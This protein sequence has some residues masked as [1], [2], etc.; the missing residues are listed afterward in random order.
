MVYRLKQLID[1]HINASDGAIGKVRD[2]YFDDHSWTIRHLVLQTGSFL[3]DRQVL[4]SPVSVASID[5]DS[6][7]VWVKL[8]VQQVKGSPPIDTDKPVSRQ[9]EAD[10]FD[11]YGYPYYWT[12]PALW[13]KATYPTGPAGSGLAARNTAGLRSEAPFDSRL[14]SAKEVTGYRLLTSTEPIGH[15][16]DFLLDSVTWAIRY[17]VV[18]T[19][20]WLPGKHVVIPPGW[21]KE[22]DWEE[23]A[24]HVAVSPVSVKEAPEFDSSS[25]FSRAYETRLY[26]HYQRAPYWQ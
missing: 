21:I 9:H 26:E 20:N 23:H 7:T 10:Y 8:T 14:R 5:W 22:V 2:L 25:E 13:L 3:S 12:D 1:L 18:D 24:V 11:H 17:V 15:V 4:I 16:E 19:R 6:R